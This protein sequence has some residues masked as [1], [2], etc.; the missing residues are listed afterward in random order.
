MTL[1]QAQNTTQIYSVNTTSR[2][3]RALSNL[4][5]KLDAQDPAVAR[6]AAAMLTS[7]IFFAPMLAEMRKLP[8]GKEFGHGGRMEDA[9]GEQMDT[10][11]ADSV[12]RSDRG[13][14]AQIARK[15]M[16]AESKTVSESPAVA[17]SPAVSWTT[18]LQTRGGENGGLV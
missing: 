16:P 13:L 14:T 11:I 2:N 12:A 15:L 7:Q 9:F 5:R 6:E 4:G 3:L 1:T 8:F 17:E 10:R 18:S